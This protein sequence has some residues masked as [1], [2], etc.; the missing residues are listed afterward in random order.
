MF[1]ISNLHVKPLLKEGALTQVKT[2][3]CFKST[4]RKPLS[5]LQWINTVYYIIKCKEMYKSLESYFIYLHFTFKKTSFHEPLRQSWATIWQAFSNNKHLLL[6]LFTFSPITLLFS[7]EHLFFRQFLTSR[8]SQ[9]L[10]Y[11]IFSVSTYCLMHTR[12]SSKH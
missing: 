12:Y 5:P 6:F 9:S 10:I 1:S 7:E 8:Q 2:Y 11:A 3:F 4:F